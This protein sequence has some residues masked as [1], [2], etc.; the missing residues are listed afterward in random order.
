[1]A[2]ELLESWKR[3]LRARARSEATIDA[4]LTDTRQLD[5]W[6]TAHGTDLTSAGRRD[7]E[8]FLAEMREAGKA[9]ATIA[10]RY[11]SFLQF[12]K[13]CEEEDEVDVNPM[14]KMSP[15]KVPVQPPPIIS[16]DHLTK[17]LASCDTPRGGPGRAKPT[18]DKLTFENKRDR[19]LILLLTTTGIRAGELMGMERADVDLNNGTFT[20]MGKGGRARIVAL[21]P[22]PADALDKY[23]RV[24][25]KH[26]KADLPA[27]WLGEKGRL[28]DSGLRQLLERRCDDAGI[29]RINPHRFRHTFAHE[30][31]S[32]GMSDGDLMSVAGWNSPQMLQRYGAS[33]AAERGREA[34]LR[35]FGKD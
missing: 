3:S 14:S 16:A 20:V 23:L 21:M 34:H 22:K 18:T 30:A 6:L 10:R 1:M 24:R 29:E 15:P 31:K 13:W 25:R 12:Y 2:D 4:Y 33:A 5:A 8:G 26:P 19:A 27:L 9:P 17:L 35:L 11:R 32:R 28:T 7:I